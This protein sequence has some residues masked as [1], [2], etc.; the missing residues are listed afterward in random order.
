MTKYKVNTGMN[1]PAKDGTMKR[2]EPGQTVSDIPETSASWLL[3][4]GHIEL[5][6]ATAP[7]VSPNSG[8]KE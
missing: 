4:Q 8:E 2:A 7:V 5:V 3:D 6:G 1:Y